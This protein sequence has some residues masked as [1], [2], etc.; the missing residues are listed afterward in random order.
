VGTAVGRGVAVGVGLGDRAGLEALL[1]GADDGWAAEQATR[2][3]AR[4]ACATAVLMFIPF[5]AR[6]YAPG[7]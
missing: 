4:N 7:W 3:L 6:D 2:R 5:V 1:A